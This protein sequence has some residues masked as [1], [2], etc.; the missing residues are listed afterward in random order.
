MYWFICIKRREEFSQIFYDHESVIISFDKPVEV[1]SVVLVAILE[2]L[3]SFAP[4]ILSAFTDIEGDGT[5]LLILLRAD[6]DEFITVRTPGVF[7]MNSLAVMVG[8][9]SQYPAQDLYISLHRL[10]SSGVSSLFLTGVI[11]W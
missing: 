9:T 8:W 3:F 1:I 2:S 11:Y 6:E 7:N 5:E 10:F 4:K